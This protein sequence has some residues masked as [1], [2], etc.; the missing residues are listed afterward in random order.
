MAAKIVPQSN[1]TSPA[2]VSGGSAAAAASTVP[3]GTLAKQG[4][5]AVGLGE[6]NLN[7]G[8]VVSRIGSVRAK[9]TAYATCI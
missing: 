6:A 5:H 1:T 4:Q 2:A 3:D 9:A 7:T 8:E